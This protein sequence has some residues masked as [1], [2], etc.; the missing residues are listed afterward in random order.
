[1]IWGPTRLPEIRT[2]ILLPLR[3]IVL[4]VCKHV[5]PNFFLGRNMAIPVREREETLLCASGD[6]YTLCSIV[7]LP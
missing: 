7:F 4:Q 2:S 6:L 1:M 5:I 3:K